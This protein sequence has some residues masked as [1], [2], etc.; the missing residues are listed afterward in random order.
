[1]RDNWA[2]FLSVP[3]ILRINYSL[4]DKTFCTNDYSDTNWATWNSNLSCFVLSSKLASPNTDKLRVTGPFAF[5]LVFLYFS[6]GFVRK[7]W[8][9]EYN[10]ALAKIQILIAQ[11]VL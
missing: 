7:S 5:S 6:L 11:E 10:V 1:M 9:I 4:K 3:L 2:E 8:A